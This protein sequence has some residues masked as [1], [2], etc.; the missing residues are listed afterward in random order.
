MSFKKGD[1]VYIISE[2]KNRTTGFNPK[3]RN[4][5]ANGK[6]Y[7]ILNIT[8]KDDGYIYALDM[9]YWWYEECLSLDKE[10][11][12]ERAHPNWKVISKVRQMDKRRKDLGYAI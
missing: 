1:R 11:E 8:K 5:I 6:T 9:G 7:E 3:M 2:F 12:K 4:Y 10:W